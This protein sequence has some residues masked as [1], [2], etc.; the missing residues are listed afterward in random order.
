MFELRINNSEAESQE[1]YAPLV[2]RG[3]GYGRGYGAEPA[4]EG[5]S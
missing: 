4:K 3:R 5:Q 1:D 2:G